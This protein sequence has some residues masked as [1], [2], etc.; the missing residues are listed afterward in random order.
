MQREHGKRHARFLASTQGANGLQSCH[1]GDLEVSQVLTV[2]LLCFARELVRKELDRVHRRNQRV[3]M[4]LCKVAS[5]SGGRVSRHKVKRAGK[6]AYTR[7]LPLRLTCPDIGVS[8]PV[9][10]LIL[11]R[12]Q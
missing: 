6:E 9:K 5:V 3:H 1:P 2:F 4:M 10:S 7:N 11:I 8:S 12:D